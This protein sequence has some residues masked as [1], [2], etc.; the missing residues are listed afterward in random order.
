MLGTVGAASHNCEFRVAQVAARGESG[1]AIKLLTT[2]LAV[3]ANDCDAWEE[4]ASMYLQVAVPA[5]AHPCSAREPR[6]RSSR[7]PENLIRNMETHLIASSLD[8]I[9]HNQLISNM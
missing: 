4:L 5:Q 1:A 3:Y 7:R 8:D 6:S 2:Y 9:A